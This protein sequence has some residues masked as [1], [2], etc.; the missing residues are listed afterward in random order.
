MGRRDLGNAKSAGTLTASA[1]GAMALSESFSRF[2]QLAIRRSLW[3]VL[4]CRSA[5][6]GTLRAPRL[7]SF[8]VAW[9]IRHLKGHPGRG[10]TLLGTSSS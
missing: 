3:L 4:L 1:T 2:W 8:S 5:N 9:C 7:E 10:S 6:S